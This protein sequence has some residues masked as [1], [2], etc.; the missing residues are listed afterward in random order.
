MALGLLQLHDVFAEI[1]ALNIAEI[2][3][4]EK[5]S[6]SLIAR[7]QR[8]PDREAVPLVTRKGGLGRRSKAGL[9]QKRSTRTVE[10]G[11]VS[12]AFPGFGV[13]SPCVYRPGLLADY[14]A[15]GVKS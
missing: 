13:V 8:K 7:L 1:R 5:L 3:A 12:R 9:P 6:E 11:G 15:A 4:F 2:C 10:K 14:S